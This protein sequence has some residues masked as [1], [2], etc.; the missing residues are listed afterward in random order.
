MSTIDWY[1]DDCGLCGSALDWAPVVGT[2]ARHGNPS[3]RVACETC[4]LVQVSPRPSAAE[5]EEY[6]RGAYWR[7]HPPAALRVTGGGQTRVVQPDEDG[8]EDAIGIMHRNRARAVLDLVGAGASVREIG[9][10]E[11][12]TLLAMQE[13]G[14][15]VYGVE[16]DQNQVQRARARVGLNVTWSSLDDLGH[17]WRGNGLHD[18]VDV[19]VAFHM[20]EH[21][22]DPV[23]TLRRMAALTRPGGYV[24]VEVPDLDRPSLPLTEHWQWAHLYD[25]TTGTLAATFARAGLDATVITDGGGNIRAWAHVP[26]AALETRP[27]TWTGLPGGERVA[28]RLRALE[29]QAGVTTGTLARFMGGQDV[30]LDALR[31]ELAAL[32]GDVAR[33]GQAWDEFCDLAGAMSERFDQE[34]ERQ[35]EAWHHDPWQ[36]GFARGCGFAMQRARTAFGVIANAARMREAADGRRDNG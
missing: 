5:L 15:D 33:M 11:G 20:L 28:A 10:G 25:F 12:R 9:C 21:H 14:L 27:E 24:L 19:T 22:L 34:A 32:Q 18:Q 31:A 13:A 30:D 29:G 36:L 8:Y 16:P 23:L 17:R 35:L 3:R 7:E 4:G 26:A 1:D 6:Y 2:M